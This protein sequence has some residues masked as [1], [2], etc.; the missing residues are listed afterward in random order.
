MLSCSCVI[1]AV[2]THWLHKCL[3]FLL[4]VYHVF[5]DLIIRCISRSCQTII[6]WIFDTTLS[7]LIFNVLCHF[8]LWIC[9][10]HIYIHCYWIYNWCVFDREQVRNAHQSLNFYLFLIFILL[11]VRQCYSLFMLWV[12]KIFQTSNIDNMLPKQY[13]QITHVLLMF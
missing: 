7:Y 11:R 5:S 3:L 12:V 2:K 4:T 8:F 9:N 13:S 10:K 6:L 1:I